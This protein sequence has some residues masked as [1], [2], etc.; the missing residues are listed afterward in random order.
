MQTGD[1]KKAAVLMV[2]ALVVVGVAV[3]RAIPRGDGPPPHAS[4]NAQ[5]STGE[6]EENP[7]GLPEAVFTNP[8]YHPRLA[9]E[10]PIREPGGEAASGGHTSLPT[11]YAGSKGLEPMSVG[12]E[13]ITGEGQQSKQEPQKRTVVVA[14]ILKVDT[15]AA[16]VSVDGGPTRQF[17]AGS[18]VFE[19]LKILKVE[20][21]GVIF[22]TA[23]GKTKVLVGGKFEQ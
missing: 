19:N 3:F 8:F 12:P 17:G 23:T 18:E 2:I 1:P 22:R 4:S 6:A 9:P 14:A 15:L 10:T 16:L 21:D 5:A 20:E 13:D 11:P 7:T